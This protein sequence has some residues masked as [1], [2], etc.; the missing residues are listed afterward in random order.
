MKKISRLH[1]LLVLICLTQITIAEEIQF[2]KGLEFTSQDEYANFPKQAIYRAFL[3]ERVNLPDYFPAPGAQGM[4]GSCVGW[5][6]AY[7]AR[8]YYQGAAQGRKLDRANAFSPAYVYNQ[9]RSDPSNCDAGSSIVNALNLLSRQG[10][11]RLS[12]R[13]PRETSGRWHRQRCA[14]AAPSCG[15]RPGWAG[16][17]CGTGL[18]H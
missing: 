2:S 11:A 10:V 16:R 13:E 15:A 4:Q 3:P 12:A 17:A 6:V 9:I 14:E 5:A 1:A 7:G 18:L 8:S